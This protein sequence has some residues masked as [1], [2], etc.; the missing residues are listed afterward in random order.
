M[1]LEIK[2]HRTGIYPQDR[3]PACS[4]TCGKCLPIRVVVTCRMALGPT[5]DRSL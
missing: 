1:P 2:D 5:L 4:T 3:D